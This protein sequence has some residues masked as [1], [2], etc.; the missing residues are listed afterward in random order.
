MNSLILALALFSFASS[1]D[2]VT[3]SVEVLPA[4]TTYVDEGGWH[5]DANVPIT[6]SQ[7]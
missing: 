2:D 3:L 1:S 5:A 4:I 6:C 7:L